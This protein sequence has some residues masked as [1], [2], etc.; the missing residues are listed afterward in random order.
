MKSHHRCRF[1][2]KVQG[3]RCR[4]VSAS[5]ALALEGDANGSRPFTSELKGDANGRDPF[6]SEKDQAKDDIGVATS[7]AS[8]H[9]I[10]ATQAVT[11]DHEVMSRSNPLTWDIKD[12]SL[13]GYEENPP[14]FKI[15]AWRKELEFIEKVTVRHYVTPTVMTVWLVFALICLV[16]FAFTG[17]GSSLIAPVLLSEP[18][19]VILKYYYG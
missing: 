1:R 19:S 2:V 14:S 8:S 6:A 12:V 11:D 18:V 16:R 13:G 9:L 10:G 5:D 3:K 4:L 7:K 17:D 15:E